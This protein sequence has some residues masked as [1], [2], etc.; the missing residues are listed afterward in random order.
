MYARLFKGFPWLTGAAA[1]L[2]TVATPSF[3]VDNEAALALIKKSGCN[4]CHS[5]S[6]KKEG[7]AYQETAA[8]L[9]G[10]ADAEQTLYV[11]LTTKP[12]IKVEGKEEE[13][14]ALKTKS[15]ADIRNAV[16]WILAQ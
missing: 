2:F 13:H 14:S 1:L 16:Q 6:S 15:E 8:K 12:K 5:V 9:K 10:K 3:A 11:H 7:P 4:K